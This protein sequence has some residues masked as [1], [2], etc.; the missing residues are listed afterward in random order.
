MNRSWIIITAFSISLLLTQSCAT[1]SGSGTAV[2]RISYQQT[3]LSEGNAKGVPDKPESAI[4]EKKV[5]T[6]EE[7]EKIIA[8]NE[9]TYVR[10]NAEIVSR[11][12]F[13]RSR[14]AGKNVIFPD[15]LPPA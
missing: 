14:F 7:K 10:M 1:S 4:K 12:D 6:Q 11:K 2:R 15:E 8:S 9:K 13:I 3:K 5:Q